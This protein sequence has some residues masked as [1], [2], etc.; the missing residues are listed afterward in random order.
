VARS[1]FRGNSSSSYVKPFDPATE[2]GVQ[3]PVGFWDPL[4]FT[5]DGNEATFKR[6]R[7]VELKHEGVSM[8]AA[9]GY[10]TPEH[11][12]FPGFLSPSLGLKFSDVPNGLAALSKVPSLGWVQIVF[13]AGIIEDALGLDDYKTGVPGGYG[14]KVLTSSD[15]GEKVLEVEH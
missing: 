7:S 3:E 9:M 12:K 4:G 14:W 15:P 10:I 1:F 8:A 6:R 11:Y 13:F 2:L 5:A